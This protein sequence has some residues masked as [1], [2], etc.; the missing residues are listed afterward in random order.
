[1]RVAS[2]VRRNG[3]DSKL[4][5]DNVLIS[6]VDSHALVSGFTSYSDVCHKSNDIFLRV[7]AVTVLSVISMV[8][9]MVPA[10][11]FVMVVFVCLVVFGR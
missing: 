6:P 8:A 7:V 1:M 9:V 5:L 4:D 2:F 11:V 10:V 3:Q